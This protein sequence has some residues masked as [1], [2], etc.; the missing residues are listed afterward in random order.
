MTMTTNQS[1]MWQV[2][3]KGKELCVL[4]TQVTPNSQHLYLLV[5]RCPQAFQH[6]HRGKLLPGGPPAPT[7]P[8]AAPTWSLKYRGA[9]S[10]LSR[11]LLQ[12]QLLL[13]LALDPASLLWFPSLPS[14]LPPL[15][16]RFLRK[17]HFHTDPHGRVCF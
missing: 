10:S 16:G 9:N 15:L 13:P 6:L 7:H 3:D 11:A 5:S 8:Q 12:T 1:L 4:S 2:A 14:S 17:H